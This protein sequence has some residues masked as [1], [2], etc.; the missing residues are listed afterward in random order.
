MPRNLI[1]IGRICKNLHKYLYIFTLFEKKANKIAY[2]REAKND[3]KAP[4]GQPPCGFESRPRHQWLNALR[5]C[6]AIGELCYNRLRMRF[7]QG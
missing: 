3:L 1:K 7:A 2:L 5:R 4:G 6:R